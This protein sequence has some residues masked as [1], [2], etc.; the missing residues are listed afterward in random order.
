M[1]ITD[2]AQSAAAE[3]SAE[4]TRRSTALRA[5]ADRRADAEPTMTVVR[6]RSVAHPFRRPVLTAHAR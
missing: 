1:F 6:R 3:R 2:L 5:Q 4:I